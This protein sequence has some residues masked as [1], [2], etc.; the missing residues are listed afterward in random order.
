MLIWYSKPIEAIC[1]KMERTDWHDD[2]HKRGA[3]FI[4]E[5]QKIVPDD[6]RM[7]E[8]DPINKR[9]VIWFVDS[10]YLKEFTEIYKRIYPFEYIF[11]K[12]KVYE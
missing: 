11:K 7:T 4:E 10:N 1:F 12:I 9:E 3:K 6:Y 8:S 5:I 2:Q